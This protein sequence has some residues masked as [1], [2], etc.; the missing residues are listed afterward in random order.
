MKTFGF[1]LEFNGA[2]LRSLEEKYGL[3]FYPN[4]SSVSYEKFFLKNEG[5]VTINMNGQLFG[6]ELVSPIFSDLDECL[7]QVKYY[8]DILKYEKAFISKHKTEA[9]FHIHLDKS[10]LDSWEMYQKLFKFLY[11]F[12]PEIYNLARGNDPAIRYIY[13]LHA[14][15]L[16]KEH[17]KYVLRGPSSL[18]RFKDKMYCIRFSEQTFEMRYFNSSLQYEVI[19]RY[20]EFALHFR[21]YIESPLYDMDMIDYYYKHT[22]NL[23]NLQEKVEYSEEKEKVMKRILNL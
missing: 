1:E 2:N 7:T 4:Y 21:D 11:A 19:K 22:H 15:P 8:L 9:G 10:F 14:A 13:F 23:E 5:G 16:K 6:G 12:Q 17:L 20:L 3:K 18:E